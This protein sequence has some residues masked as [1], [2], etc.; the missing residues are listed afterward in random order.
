MGHRSS[1]NASCINGQRAHNR[2]EVRQ[3]TAA[4]EAAIY[5][6]ET[7]GAETS[8][9]ETNHFRWLGLA[10]LLLFSLAGGRRW[11]LRPAERLD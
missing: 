7:D 11:I 4:G 6:L 3:H 2:L 10:A 5:P 8:I 9:Q 1:L